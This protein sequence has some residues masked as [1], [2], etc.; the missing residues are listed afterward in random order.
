MSIIPIFANRRS[1]RKTDQ[2]LARELDIP[3][4]MA[5]RMNE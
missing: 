5:R 1:H 2:E 4:D 3:L